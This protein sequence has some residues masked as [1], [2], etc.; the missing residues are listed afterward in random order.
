MDHLLKEIRRV[1]RR[2]ALQR[3]LDVLGWCWLASLVAA[4]FVIG[5]A[6]FY[7]LGIADWQWLAG[8]L[9]AGLAAAAVRAL[10]FATPP[11]EAAMEIDHRF[12]LKE[13]V[14]SAL[15]M[16]PA[17]RETVA[18]QALIDDADE[19]LRHIAIA[20][21]FPVRPP[22]R[23]LLPLLPA[24]LIVAVMVFRP[25]LTET[26]AEATEAAAVQPPLEV[27]KSAEDLRQRL[28]ER[29]KQAEKDGL[30]DATELLKQLEERTKELQKQTQR[31]QALV[32]LKDLAQVL[33]ERRQ[34]LG[35]GSEALKRQ[36]EK[37]ANVPRG[38]ADELAKA[39][40]KGDFQKAAQA[41]EKLQ[42]ELAGSKIDPAKRGPGQA[43]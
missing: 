22:R 30:K 40:S 16:H 18:G 21:K 26:V 38:P 25:P 17:D 4:A 42:K 31:E 32:Q 2:M 37:I 15:A 1:Q 28:V 9:A 34:Q 27:K 43:A 24:L 39:L 3:F 19:R 41:L 35:G 29:R 11:L 7:P 36:M 6:R 10:L 8:L 5:T 14:S 20:E 13:R 23:I 12:A 33:Q